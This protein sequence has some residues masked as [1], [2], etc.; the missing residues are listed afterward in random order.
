M[1]G[2]AFRLSNGN[3]FIT[4][5]QFGHILEI[6]INENIVWEYE[7]P[8]ENIIIARAQKY[9]INY[10]ENF[11]IGD[12]NQDGIVNVLDI[13]SSVTIILDNDYNELADL[14]QDGFINVVDIIQ[15]INIILY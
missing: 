9:S 3:T 1:Q 13:I 15:I 11:I 8:D 14:N 10:L 4:V 7:H 2:G 5:A 6:D 12:I